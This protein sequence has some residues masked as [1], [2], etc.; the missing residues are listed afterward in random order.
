MKHLALIGTVVMCLVSAPL[1][2]AQEGY[3]PRL[4]DLMGQ[5]Q[6]RHIKL[7]FAGKLQNWEL[8]DYEVGQIKSSLEDAAGLYRS[9][10]VEAV[11]ITADP[12]QRITEAIAAKDSAKFAKAYEGLTAA[13]NACHVAIDR[14]FIVIQVPT[15]SPFRDQSFA[16]GG[17]Q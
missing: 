13:C 11:T 4:A 16:P 8:A 1:A 9:I 7:W 6:L 15:A 10:P 12:L 17:K 2:L 14:G 3:M 5:I